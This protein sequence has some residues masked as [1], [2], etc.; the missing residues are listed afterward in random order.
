MCVRAEKFSCASP[1]GPRS[2]ESSKPSMPSKHSASIQLTLRQSI[3]STFITACP[4]MKSR[5]ATRTR[6]TKLG[7]ADGGLRYEPPL[8]DA[9]HHDLRRLHRD[10]HDRSEG[11]AQPS[12]ECVRERSNWPLSRATGP[13]AHGH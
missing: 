13:E 5:A 10:H 3:G 12:L 7:C 9:P 11:A 4:S 2:R 8:P 1:A 6:G